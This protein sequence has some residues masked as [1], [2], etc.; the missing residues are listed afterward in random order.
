MGFFKDLKGDFS[1]AVDELVATAVTD[2]SDITDIEDSEDVMVNTLDEDIEETK[3]EVEETVETITETVKNE[4][5]MFELTSNKKSDN[6]AII[7]K[8][9]LLT[10]DMSSDDDIEVYGKVNGNITCRGKVFI[11]GEVNGN[12]EGLKV[13]ICGARVNGDIICDGSVDIADKSIIQG[14]VMANTVLMAGAIKGDIDV[15]GHVVIDSS[16]IIVGDIKSK[17]VQINV[18]AVIEG[19][20]SQCY[21]DVS[22]DKIFGA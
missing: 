15:N 13:A 21:A 9:V 20:C 14:N 4:V 5:P 11:Y 2:G 10:G 16:A 22:P 3:D 18:G 19:R 12:I 17:T 7:T 8:G 1:Q 6:V